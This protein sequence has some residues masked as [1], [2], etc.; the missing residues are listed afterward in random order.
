MKKVTIGLIGALLVIMFTSN[1]WAHSGLR[2]DLGGSGFGFS[3][4]DGHSGFSTFTYDNYRPYPTITPDIIQIVLI[5]DGAVITDIDI[6]TIR[7]IGVSIDQ[8]IITKA[9]I[10]IIGEAI[11]V[12][13]TVTTEESIINRV[14]IDAN[15]GVSSIVWTG[16]QMRLDKL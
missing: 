10:I 4:S 13:T 16:E 9:T 1:A 11:N 15:G 14:T 2:I 3:I 12:G 7:S 8:G 5:W 6:I